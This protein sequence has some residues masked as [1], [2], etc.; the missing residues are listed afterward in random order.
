MQRW[1]RAFRVGDFFHHRRGFAFA[2]FGN[3]FGR[4]FFPNLF[5]IFAGTGTAVL[6]FIVMAIGFELTLQA[7]ERNGHVGEHFQ[8]A[9][10]HQGQGWCLHTTC[11]P[12]SLFATA[13]QAAC[14]RARGVDSNQ[15]VGFGT[16]V[17]RSTQAFKIFARPQLLESIAD[18]GLGHGLQPQT[19]DRLA[20]IG[21]LFDLAENQLALSRSIT[22]V[23]KTHD[24]R[25]ASQLLQK[26]QL[27]SLTTPRTPLKWVRQDWQVGQRPVFQLWIVIFGLRELQKVTDGPR[28]QMVWAFPVAI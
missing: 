5:D 10:H 24:F 26:S 3:L 7:P 23:D 28:N 16:T 12:H 19:L 9:V 15:P 2:T 25:P 22:C 6:T 18:G 20:A 27:G 11:R 8:L 4:C 1:H 17:G 14:N 13:F 21:V